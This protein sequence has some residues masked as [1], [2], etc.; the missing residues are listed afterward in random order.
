MAEHPPSE[1]SAAS[2]AP[3]EAGRR[4]AETVRAAHAARSDATRNQGGWG[5]WA[6]PLVATVGV[7]IVALPPERPEEA[8]RKRLDTTDVSSTPDAS[9]PPV[10]LVPGLAVY[11]GAVGD[12]E[13]LDDGATVRPGEALQLAYTAGGQSHGV[14]FS[15]D[16]DGVVHGLWPAAPDGTTALDAGAEV[17]LHTPW[18][19]SDARRF[20]R[21]YFVTATLPLDIEVVRAAAQ[22]LA[23]NGL[24]PTAL[25][26]PLQ[27]Q[28]QQVTLLFEKPDSP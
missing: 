20:E 5:L 2:P 16:G 22:D 10:P 26:L 9:M 1:P 3:D 7:M 14:I 18:T 23:D 28:V 17:R 13:R 15:I 19:V 12:A 11:R 21:L 4:K 25:A 6:V 27:Q 24:A 8:A